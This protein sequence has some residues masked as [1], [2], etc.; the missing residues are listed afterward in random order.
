MRSPTGEVNLDAVTNA[1]MAFL[2][3]H[4]EYRND[5]SLARSVVDSL[6]ELRR[7]QVDLIQMRLDF[8]EAVDVPVARNLR[9]GMGWLTLV[10]MNAWERIDVEEINRSL[11]A[12]AIKQ[13]TRR[14]WR[15]RWRPEHIYL[16]EVLPEPPS[17]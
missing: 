14:G 8:D 15:L 6:D 1:L 4:P 11:T 13:E 2:A 7:P 10:G 5:Y 16:R 9:V 12:Q 3:G 17:N